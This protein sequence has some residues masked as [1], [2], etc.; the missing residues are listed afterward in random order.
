MDPWISCFLVAV[1]SVRALANRAETNLWPVML[2]ER[3]MALS[4]SGVEI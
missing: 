2:I 1:T 3:G 4:T